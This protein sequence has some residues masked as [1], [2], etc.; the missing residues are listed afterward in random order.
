LKSLYGFPDQQLDHVPAIEIIQRLE[1][2]V[3][4][5][6]P[7]IVYTHHP[8]DMNSDHRVVSHALLAA[9]RPMTARGRIHEVLAFE[10]PSSTDQ[11]PNMPP[12][13]FEPN[14]FVAVHEVWKHK[15]EALAIYSNEIMDFP[16]PRSLK[17]IEALAMKRGAECGF[18]MAEAFCL[19]RS[20]R[21]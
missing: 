4:E 9:I 2:D 16:H 13:S 12:Y 21:P 3:T 8:G 15:I 14:C 19:I 1:K 18:P 7:D 6:K 17:M 5:L 11:A 20:I 10:T